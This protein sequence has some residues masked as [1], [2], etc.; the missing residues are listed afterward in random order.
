MQ[1]PR[2]LNHI[3]QS[4]WPGE[5]W[6]LISKK[7]NE[8]GKY[9]IYTNKWGY[10]RALFYSP[11]HYERGLKSN[12]FPYTIRGPDSINWSKEK[13]LKFKQKLKKYLLVKVPYAM[14]MEPE[15]KRNHFTKSEYKQL[16]RVRVKIR[17]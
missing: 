7:P 13:K 3:N 11:E 14:C 15:Y 2:F 6:I 5:I 17:A 10:P 12:L 8:S 1:T 4:N 16:E 9:K